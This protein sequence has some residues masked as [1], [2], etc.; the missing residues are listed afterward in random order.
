MKTEY[1]SRCAILN[2]LRRWLEPGVP[3]SRGVL[4][5]AASLGAL[6]VA[7]VWIGQRAPAQSVPDEDAAVDQALQTCLDR[8]LVNRGCPKDPVAVEATV[9][10]AFALGYP[11][12]ANRDRVQDPALIAAKAAN[13]A[14]F[15][16]ARAYEAELL[17]DPVARERQEQALR[18]LTPST[19]Q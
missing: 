1:A 6:L 17:K 14:T 7:G 18:D 13:D 9:A 19:G 8:L 15:L 5:V 16:N 11:E 2:G 4:V 3:R 10:A 12:L